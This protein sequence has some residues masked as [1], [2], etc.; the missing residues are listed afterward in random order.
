MRQ[1]VLLNINGINTKVEVTYGKNTSHTYHYCFGM[2]N[3]QINPRV[4]LEKLSKD[5]E[6]VFTPRV[7]SKFN[8]EPFYTHDFIYVFGNIS[9]FTLKKGKPLNFD[10]ILVENRYGKNQTLKQILYDV[11]K[12]RVEYYEK[13]MNLPSH[14]VKIKKLSAVLGN[15]HVRTHILAFNEKLVHF[16]IE[17]IDSVIVHELCHD[18]YQNHSANFYRKIDEYC[19]NYKLKREKILLGVRK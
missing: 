9:S 10:N 7:L 8:P 15:N 2:I 19:Q 17:L 1:Q 11:I 6:K 14:E 5:L 12:Q 4:S 3:A 13:I 16:S 18:F